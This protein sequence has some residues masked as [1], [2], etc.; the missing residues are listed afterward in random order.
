[1]KKERKFFYGWVI[2]GCCF[3]ICMFPMVLIS[4]AFSY[5]QVPVCSDLGINYVQFSAANIASTFA[6]MLFSFFLAGKLSKGNTRLFM[7]IG[8]L[9]AALGYF[10][11]SYI[12]AIWQLYLTFFVA[13]MGFSAMTYVP[14]NFLISNWFVDRKGLATSIAFTGIGIGGALFTKPL[15]ALIETSGWRPSFRLTALVVAI[16]AVVV[17]LLVRK[18]PADMGLKPYRRPEKEAGPQAGTPQSPPTSSAWEGVTKKE[19]VR[20]SAF[21]IFVIAIVCC[22][23]LSAGIMTQLPTFLTEVSIPFAGVMALYSGVS[24]VSKLVMGPTFDKLGLLPGAGITAAM[25]GMALVA[26]LFAPTVSA[27]ASVS[28]VLLAFGISVGTLAPPLLTGQLFGNKEFGGIYGLANV[29]YMGGCM[30][31]PMISSSIRTAVGTY[32]AAWCVYIAVCVLLVA[33]T[34]VSLKLGQ[35]LRRA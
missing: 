28:A 8:G 6:G 25:L 35:R 14:I 1:M 12:T 15:A 13:N 19:A 5:Y 23:I 16:T 18:A 27:M 9:V 30:V 4:S 11:Q 32:S 34:A 2:V 29:F 3:L 21:W 17:F 7:L 10:A 26:L 33:A 24:I 22:G 20:S 31:G